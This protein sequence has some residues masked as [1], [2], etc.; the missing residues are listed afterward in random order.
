MHFGLD[1]GKG[2]KRLLGERLPDPAAGRRIP[3][4]EL[5]LLIDDPQAHHQRALDAGVVELGAMAVRDW[6]HRAAYNLDPDGHVLVF[7]EPI[8]STAV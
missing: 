6:A 1:V 8:E 5:Y 2:T 4:L 3:R 7:A